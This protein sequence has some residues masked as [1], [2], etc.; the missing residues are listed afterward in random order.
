MVADCVLC[1]D[2]TEVLRL[3][4][5]NIESNLGRCATVEETTT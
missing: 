1:E 3:I 4:Q 2:G 5:M